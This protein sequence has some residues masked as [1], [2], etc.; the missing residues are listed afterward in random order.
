[1]KWENNRPSDQIEDR[2]NSPGGGGRMP[3]M[4]GG[5]G[6]G[7]G[8]I[9]IALVGGWIFGINPMTILGALS[10]GD[11]GAPTA[12]TQRVD[13]PAGAPTDPTARVHKSNLAQQVCA[14]CH[15]SRGEGKIGPNLTDKFW[16]YGATQHDLLVSIRDGRPNG[17]PAWGGVLLP[18]QL[19]SMIAYLDTLRGQDLPGKEPQGDPVE[20]APVAPPADPVDAVIDPVAPPAETP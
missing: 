12:Q 19:V 8:T 13:T 15:A 16:L 17:M 20:A 3:R 10:G 9:V 1:M 11:L 18:Q 7:I 14:E 4:G 5:R 2:R 6:I